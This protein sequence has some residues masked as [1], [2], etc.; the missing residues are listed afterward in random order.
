MPEFSV[1]LAKLFGWNRTAVLLL[2]IYNCVTMTSSMMTFHQND[3][4][5]EVVNDSD[6]DN[7]GVN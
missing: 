5:S 3:V 7:V 6:D 4:N 1:M 2:M